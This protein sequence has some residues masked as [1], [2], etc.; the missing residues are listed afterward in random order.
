MAEAD[1]LVVLPTLGDRLALLEETLESVDAQRVTTRLRLVVVLPPGAVQAR[2]LAEAHGATL[3]EDP[4]AGISHAINLGVAA[5]DGERYYAWIGD[6]DLFR[7]GGLRA[8]QEL[9][10][11]RRDA[12]LAFGACDYVDLDGRLLF[13]NRAGRLA[14]WLLPWGPDLIPHPGSL[15]HIDAM[16]RVG[17][18]DEDLR[19]AMDLDL[20]LKLRRE[21]R[22]VATRTSVSAFRWHVASLTVAGRRK[23]S[24]EADLVKRRHLPRA[25]R[26][27]SPTW[28]LPVRVAASYAARSVSRRAAALG[29]V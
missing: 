13:T 11:S 19:Y 4:G 21:G 2:A 24:A 25:L 26:P 5:A 8:L 28:S 22:F 12:V 7:P 20:F 23:S 18:F 15:I 1:V 16:R 10:E 3:V 17:L 27:L 29:P 14:R 6:D 9:L